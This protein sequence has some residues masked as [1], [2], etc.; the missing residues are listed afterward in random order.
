MK[1]ILYTLF[2]ILLSC[3]KANNFYQGRVLDENG[4]P[5]NGVTVMDESSDDNQ[6]KTDRTGYFKLKKS[7]D[8][9]GTLVF[10]KYGYETDTIPSVWRQAGEKVRYYFIE[11]DTTVVRLKFA[12]SIEKL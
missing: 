4:K 11:K 3:K 9:L 7:P 5:L 10:R 12:K 1:Y 6:T 2:F 8:W